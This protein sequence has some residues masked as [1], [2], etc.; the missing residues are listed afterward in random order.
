MRKLFKSEIKILFKFIFNIIGINLNEFLKKIIKIYF[1]RNIKKKIFIF[2][3]NL[4]NINTKGIKLV[5]LGVFIGNFI[6][7]RNMKNFKINYFSLNLF[8]HYNLNKV[9]IKKNTL[10][11]ILSKYII[12]EKDIAL[13]SN[14]DIKLRFVTVYTEEGLLLGCGFMILNNYKKN[15]IRIKSIDLFCHL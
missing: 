14:L 7:K 12:H 8:N 9:W 6:K 4:F 2:N 10:R 13:I 5:S 1:L 3:K 15:L 11:D